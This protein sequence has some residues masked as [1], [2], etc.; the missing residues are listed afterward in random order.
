[1][2]LASTFDQKVKIIDDIVSKMSDDEKRLILQKLIKEDIKMFFE[3]IWKEQKCQMKEFGIEDAQLL[4][5]TSER[6]WASDEKVW[7]D[8]EEVNSE[9]KDIES[10]RPENIGK[11]SKE[12]EN[13]WYLD[14]KRM[15]K[16]GNDRHDGFLGYINDDQK[17]NEEV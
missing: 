8:G 5:D 16:L 14:Q 4:Q 6:A 2:S 12:A 10:V 15:E 3:T 13:M 7:I 9:E 11:V 1:M 17:P